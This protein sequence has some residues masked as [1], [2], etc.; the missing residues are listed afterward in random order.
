MQILEIHRP[1][2]SGFTRNLV[3]Q[4]PRVPSLLLGTGLARSLPLG[5]GFAENLP[6]GRSGTRLRARVLL[7][8]SGF[9]E[10]LPPRPGRDRFFSGQVSR[11]TP[12]PRPVGGPDLTRGPVPP[13]RV[14]LGGKLPPLPAGG[15]TPGPRHLELLHSRPLPATE[16]EISGLLKQ[17]PGADRLEAGL[18]GPE[19]A[20]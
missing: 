9:A 6:P 7:L 15:Q 12:L 17:G 10:N 19:R 14:R 5:S 4:M 2:G 13:S 20:A 11:K 18:R 16:I 1:L 8:G 3:P